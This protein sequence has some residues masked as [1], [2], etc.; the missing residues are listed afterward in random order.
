VKLVKL[1]QNKTVKEIEDEIRKANFRWMNPLAGVESTRNTLDFA[2]R[3][4]LFVEPDLSDEGLTLAEVVERCLPK[5]TQPGGDQKPRKSNTLSK[6]RLPI[7]GF[8]LNGLPLEKEQSMIYLPVDFSEKSLTRKGAIKFEWSSY[9]P[10]HLSFTGKSRLPVFRH[11][12]AIQEHSKSSTKHGE[13][14]LSS[15]VNLINHA[16][17]YTHPISYRKQ[18]EPSLCFSTLWETTP[19]NVRAVSK[20]STMSTSKPQYT[21]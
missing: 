11:A 14:L 1:G 10:D 7:S 12:S 17:F 18:S 13:S 3:L 21:L 15:K 20:K 9:L 2:I 4:W 16:V 8:G 5:R 6:A 19:Q